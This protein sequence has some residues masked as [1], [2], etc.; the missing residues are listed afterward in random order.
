VARHG[1]AALDGILAAEEAERHLAG[2]P[3]LVLDRLVDG[4]QVEQLADRVV[5]HADD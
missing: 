3:A 2:D 4:R 1:D 5:V